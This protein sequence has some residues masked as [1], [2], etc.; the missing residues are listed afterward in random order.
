MSD[1]KSLPW[2]PLGNNQI[3]MKPCL[4]VFMLPPIN[5]A[6]AQRG[7]GLMRKSQ[8]I[9]SFQFNLNFYNKISFYEILK[10]IIITR[11]CEKIFITF[12]K[13]PLSPFKYY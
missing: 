1:R 8:T 10:G 3:F 4:S 5:N 9:K 6:E 11:G 12:R 2:I 13:Y 7:C